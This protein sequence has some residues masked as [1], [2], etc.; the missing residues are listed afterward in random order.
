MYSCLI[1]LPLSVY[2]VFVS[3]RINITQ[4]KKVGK[5]NSDEF[6]GQIEEGTQRS[7]RH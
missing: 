2:T 5:N 3:K 7:I 4:P 1:K 6:I